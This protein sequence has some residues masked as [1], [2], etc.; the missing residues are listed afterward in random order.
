MAVRP[1]AQVSI[2]LN[3]G[4]ADDENMLEATAIRLRRNLLEID[5]ILGVTPAQ[6]GDAPPGSK[7]LD[8]IAAGTLVVTVIAT[9]PHLRTLVTATRAALGGDRSV[10]LEIGGDSLTVTGVDSDEQQ[11]LINLW[12]E[13]HQNSLQ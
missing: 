13:R 5:E 2:Q 10:T 4:P 7:G 6:A 11:R 12:L 3:P 9:A 1:S 8:V